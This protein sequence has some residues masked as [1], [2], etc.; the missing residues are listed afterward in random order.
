MTKTSPVLMRNFHNRLPIG[1]WG[2]LCQ[3]M[4]E[5]LLMSVPRRYEAQPASLTQTLCAVLG[6][7]R[8]PQSACRPVSGVGPSGE[9]TKGCGFTVGETEVYEPSLVDR[10]RYLLQYFNPPPI[11]LNQIINRAEYRRNLSLRPNKSGTPRMNDPRTRIRIWLGCPSCAG[12]HMA[13]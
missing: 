3:S 1:Q 4:Y 5:V 9:S 13:L 11:V 10:L 6:G 8:D 7:S 2:T 12:L